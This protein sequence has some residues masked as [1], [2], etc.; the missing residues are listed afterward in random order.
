MDA[1][2]STQVVDE[3]LL[4]AEGVTAAH[5]QLAPFMR[6]NPSKKEV[7]QPV[8]PQIPQLPQDLQEDKPVQSLCTVTSTLPAIMKERCS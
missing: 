1:A 5:A 7:S 3:K 4:D 2:V 6:Q 8:G